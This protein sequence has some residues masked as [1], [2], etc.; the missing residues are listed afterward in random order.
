M[1]PFDHH[2]NLQSI[3][4]SSRSYPLAIYPSHMS[5]SIFSIC[6]STTIPH[7]LSFSG[8]SN[9]EAAILI[10]ASSLQAEIASSSTVCG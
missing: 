10:S 6:L 5:F 7:L 2:G 1:L 8:D 4:A 9:S 3:L